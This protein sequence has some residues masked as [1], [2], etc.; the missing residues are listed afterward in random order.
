MLKRIGKLN[1]KLIAVVG[2]VLIVFLSL[3]MWYSIKSSRETSI[4]E[5]ERW[6][7]LLAETVR[8]SMNTLMKED[9]MDARFGMFDSMRA[10]IPGL[11]KIQIIRGEKV[12]ELFMKAREEKDIPR[13]QR[14]IDSYRKKIE[15]LNAK[16]KATQNALE[17]KDIESDISDAQSGIDR[18]EKKILDL[19]NIK[20]DP[21]EIP[22]HELAR[23]V[24]D[25]GNPFF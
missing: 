10:E 25:T 19:R 5:I 9:K 21:S 7:L 6:S 1:L 13:E 3:D 16:L 11:E 18:A 24:L 22:D 14:A 17:R 8:V 23:K 15:D 2:A 4:K 12:N 20:T